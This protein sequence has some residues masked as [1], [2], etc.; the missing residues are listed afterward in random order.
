[1]EKYRLSYTEFKLYKKLKLND[2]K[3]RT[4]RNDSNRTARHSQ[5]FKTYASRLVCR[6]FFQPFRVKKSFIWSASILT[7]H[8]LQNNWILICF[9]LSIGWPK[10]EMSFFASHCL[11]KLSKKN[12]RNFAKKREWKPMKTIYI[13][14]NHT[15]S[16]NGHWSIPNIVIMAAPKRNIN[17]MKRVSANS[18]KV[19][20][21]FFFHLS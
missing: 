3:S 10:N 13:K 7:L 19:A 14:I 4:Y 6:T 11:K 9:C 5:K 8:R 21:H 18:E 20:A 15:Q 1:M 17:G 2:K 12:R 16:V